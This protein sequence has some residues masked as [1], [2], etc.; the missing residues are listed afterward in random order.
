MDHE[1]GSIAPGKFAD[2]AVLEADP[3]QEDPMELRNIGVWGTMVGGKTHPATQ[4]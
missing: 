4:T 2:L 1:I 3:Y